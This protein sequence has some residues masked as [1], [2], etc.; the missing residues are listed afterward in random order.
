MMNLRHL[1]LINSKVT[2]DGLHAIR[3]ALPN[4]T[5]NNLPPNN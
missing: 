5:V 1:N 4:C 3:T 2:P